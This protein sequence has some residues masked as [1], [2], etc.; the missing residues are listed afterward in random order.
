M[1]QLRVAL[2]LV[3]FK[4]DFSKEIMNKDSFLLLY[5]QWEKF[6]SFIY[7]CWILLFL[8]PGLDGFYGKTQDNLVHLIFQIILSSVN[9]QVFYM[10]NDQSFAQFPG[11]YKIIQNYN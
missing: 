9:K 10:T 2:I 1:V 8:W 3:L 5:F 11:D 6:C 4:Y 7:G